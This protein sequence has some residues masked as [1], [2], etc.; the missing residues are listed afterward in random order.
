[1]NDTPITDG[2]EYEVIPD[3]TADDI[4]GEHP[5]GDYPQNIYDDDPNEPIDEDD[6]AVPEGEED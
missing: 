4:D 5:S 1:M 6:I 2:N 3:D